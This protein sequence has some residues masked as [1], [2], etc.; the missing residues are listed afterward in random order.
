M[1]FASITAC[2]AE[3]LLFSVVRQSRQTHPHTALNC[4]LSKHIFVIRRCQLDAE[5]VAA[6]PRSAPREP[7]TV[8]DQVY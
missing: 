7:A 1:V 4:Q 5:A 2:A 6:A 3:T 8:T